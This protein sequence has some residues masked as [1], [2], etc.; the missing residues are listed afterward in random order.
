[1]NLPMNGTSTSLAHSV[2]D[3]FSRSQGKELVRRQNSEV[4]HGL[5]AA[6]RVQAAAMV[7]AVG[8]Q[9]AGMLSREARFQENGDP[10]ANNRLQHL[11]DQFALFAG[12]EIARFGF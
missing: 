5:V 3:G 1:M 7:A 10:S 2:P 4:A 12:S 6:T 11:A 9:C 8:M